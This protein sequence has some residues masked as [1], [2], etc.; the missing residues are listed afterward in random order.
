MKGNKEGMPRNP[1][2]RTLSVLNCPGGGG[3][4]FE[5]QPGPRL[6]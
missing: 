5:Y 4:Q 1:K 2:S 3:A 6:S